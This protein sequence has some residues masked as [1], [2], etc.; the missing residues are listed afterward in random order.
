MKDNYYILYGKTLLAL[1]ELR[2]LNDNDKYKLNDEFCFNFVTFFVSFFAWKNNIR[3]TIKIST[4]HDVLV[5][6][7]T[8]CRC[9][10][11][12]T[13]YQSNALRDCINTLRNKSETETQYIMMFWNL[14]RFH[15]I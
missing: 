3:K 6:Y 9:I 2:P 4:L 14:S 10:E 12:Y 1:R 11:T 8:L 15:Q 7:I 13:M 5:G